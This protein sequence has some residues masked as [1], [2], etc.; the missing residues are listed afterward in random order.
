MRWKRGRCVAA[1]IAFLIFAGQEAPVT[2][3]AI[4]TLEV[5]A[6]GAAAPFPEAR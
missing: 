1:H 3:A 4:V 2:H 5:N 6:A